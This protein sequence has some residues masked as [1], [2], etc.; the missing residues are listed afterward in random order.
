MRQKC[1]IKWHNVLRWCSG[2][3]AT[4][5]L[6]RVAHCSSLLMPMRQKQI[7]TLPQRIMVIDENVIT[8]LKKPLIMKYTHSTRPEIY[9][10]IAPG[11]LGLVIHVETFSGHWRYI[12]KDTDLN[13]RCRHLKI[14]CYIALC[15]AGFN[16][17]SKL[18]I[19]LN[20]IN[21]INYI[22]R[23]IIY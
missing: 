21:I 8:G 14:L 2:S 17:C 6:R 16:H 10:T 1:A 13:P 3:S 12:G 20:H 4:N 19:F 18:L 15:P 9:H 7:W 22:D 23:I 11:S 5:W